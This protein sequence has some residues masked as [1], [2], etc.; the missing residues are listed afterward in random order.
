MKGIT[1]PVNAGEN[2]ELVSS[3]AG[4]HMEQ[5]IQDILEVFSSVTVVLH[6]N[7]SVSVQHINQLSTG[8]Y[9]HGYVASGCV[10]S[11]IWAVVQ[12]RPAVFDMGHRLFC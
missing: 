9:Y 12:V 6:S 10:A 8:Q 3:R 4:I 1:T 11:S 7:F 2:Q 5:I